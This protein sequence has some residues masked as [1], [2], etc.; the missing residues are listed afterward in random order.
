MKKNYKP[1]IFS[2]L[3]IVFVFIIGYTIAYY[4]SSDKFN[5]LFKTGTYKMVVQETF[6]SPEKWKPGD[7]TSKNIYAFNKGTTSAAVRMKLTPSWTD[8]NGNPLELTD[9]DDNE[10]ALI[11][12]AT[13]WESD[14]IYS[15][16][17]YYYNTALNP[18]ESTPFLIKSVT[19]NPDAKIDSEKTCTEN[20]TTHKTKC[21]TRASYGGGKYKLI[22]DIETVQ[23]DKYQEIWNTDVEIEGSVTETQILL[24]NIMQKNAVMDNVASKY[25]SSSSGINFSERSSNTN[26]KGIYT[27]SSTANDSYPIMYY[28]G[29]VNNNNL[30]IANQCWKIVRTTDTGGA[31]I[32]YSGNAIQYRKSLAF[33]DYNVTNNRNSNLSF[34]PSTTLWK[35][36]WTNSEYVDFSFKVPE[37]D[38]YILT[39]QFATFGHPGASST[40]GSIY[41]YKN[42]E[43]VYVNGG[44]GGSLITT[45][46]AFGHLT[47]DDEITIKVYGLSNEINPLKVYAQMHHGETETSQLCG[48]TMGYLYH[49]A[50]YTSSV[51]SELS[52]ERVSYMFDENYYV[53]E[54]G[55]ASSHNS[56]YFGSDVTY[57]NNVYKLVDPVLGYNSTHLYSC[58]STDSNGTCTD[59]YYYAN[60]DYYVK[61]SNGDNIDNFYHNEVETALKNRIDFVYSSYLTDYTNYF[62]DTPWCNDRSGNKSLSSTFSAYNRVLNGTPS[63]SCSKNDSFTVSNNNGNKALT[64]PTGAL[65]VDELMYAGLTQNDTNSSNYLVSGGS[66]WTM[67]PRSYDKDNGGEIYIVTANG[68]IDSVS[69]VIQNYY[70]RGAVSLKHDTMIVGGNGTPRNPYRLAQ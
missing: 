60:N 22:V 24:Y 39:I 10:V 64:Y 62:E 36:I 45:D 12:F 55:N 37:D 14:W 57:E 63:L 27:I 23:F 30:T 40:G 43:Q 67:T 38:D 51:M 70:T 20:P 4:T 31:K 66:Y 11:N 5:N 9:I 54:S 21:V 28:R 32:I 47:S 50:Y 65:T 61:F 3:L 16:G 17:Y 53:L 1:I 25:V 13:G 26:G 19:F 44:G 34:D 52:P 7:T 29:N 48:E 6:E 58:H 69:S 59:V 46:Y 8:K 2:L 15:D 68:K 42:G 41:I 35:Y 18:N 56:H 49:I 33:E